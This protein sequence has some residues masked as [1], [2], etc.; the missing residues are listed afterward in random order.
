MRERCWLAAEATFPFSAARFGCAPRRKQCQE[1]AAAAISP[2]AAPGDKLWSPKSTAASRAPASH[3]PT[4]TFG[5]KSCRPARLGKWEF[6]SY[7]RKVRKRI[8]VLTCNT[9]YPKW[10]KRT[11]FIGKFTQVYYPSRSKNTQK[12]K[13]QVGDFSRVCLSLYQELV[14]FFN[15][16]PAAHR[17]RS[18]FLTTVWWRRVYFPQVKFMC[19]REK[20]HRVW[21]SRPR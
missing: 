11:S 12:H 19:G 2:P 8:N 14:P 6:A 3:M 10:E 17:K 4:L 5:Q 9:H 7:S 13:I 16:I 15:F 1:A 18:S 20:S 21:P